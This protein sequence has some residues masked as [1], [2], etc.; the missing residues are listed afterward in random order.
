[1]NRDPTGR[2]RRIDSA[3]DWCARL[4]DGLETIEEQIAFESWLAA[5]PDNHRTFERMAGLWRALP[6]LADDA[7]LAEVRADALRTL[8]EASTA[9]WPHHL[10]RRWRALV[11]FAACFVLVALG[12]VYAL[13]PRTEVYATGVGE[14]RVVKLADGSRI[15]LDAASRLEVNYSSERRTLH[16]FDGRAKFDVAKDPRRPFTVAAG[17]KIVVATGTA[18]SVELINRQMYVVLYEGNVAVLENTPADQPPRHVM[19][20][21][22]RVAADYNLKP[23]RALVA[24]LDKATGVIE[25]IDPVRSLAWEGGQ[26]NFAD[27]PLAI[28]VERVNRYSD[29]KLSVSGAAA[30]I[31]VSGTFNAGDVE[32]FVEAMQT[33][34]PLHVRR[35]GNQIVLRNAGT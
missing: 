35:S 34:Y 23:G 25:G 9:R 31:P 2:Q 10:L 13:Q 3:A 16:L 29:L 30:A 27:E 15:S 14:R 8:G 12:V 4:A 22:R 7:S 17:G 32:S 20:E 19:L 6:G 28:A 26:L 11:A 21:A 24:S 5:D 33:L 1:M 18:F